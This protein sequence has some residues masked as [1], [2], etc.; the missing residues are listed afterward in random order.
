MPGSVTGV[1]S[2]VVSRETTQTATRRATEIAR[3]PVNQGTSTGAG[4]RRQLSR[5]AR[6]ARR[7]AAITNPSE[8]GG[9]EGT[10]E[11]TTT[12]SAPAARPLSGR[13]AASPFRSWRRRSAADGPGARAGARH[14]QRRAVVLLGL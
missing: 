7:P 11:L 14:Q 13:A 12:R 8:A 4:S 6:L 10:S 2:G 1:G 9:G 3:A 5:V